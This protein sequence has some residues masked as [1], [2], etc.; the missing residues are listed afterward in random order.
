M[1]AC[2][3]DANVRHT[4]GIHKGLPLP[5]PMVA[6]DTAPNHALLARLVP[7]Q[8]LLATPAR[9]GF[10]AFITGGVAGF[11][12]RPQGA[13]RQQVIQ[14][15]QHLHRFA[16]DDVQIQPQRTQLR[17]EVGRAFH[18]KPVV[19]ARHIGLRQQA[20]LNNIQTEH[21]A[22]PQGLRQGFVVEHPKIAFEPDQLN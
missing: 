22:S 8:M 14:T 12:V 9:H 7:G 17:P 16:G 5:L 18:S 4:R 10:V 15:V 2:G 19:L 13:E 11:L 21:R 6:V 3:L 20:G 1:G